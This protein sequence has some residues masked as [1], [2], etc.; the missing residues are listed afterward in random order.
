V[1]DLAT[2][3]SGVRKS[4][5]PIYKHMPPGFSYLDNAA[6]THSPQ[7][8]MQAVSGYYAQIHANPHSGSHT[9]SEQSASQYHIARETVAR[10]IHAPGPEQIIFCHS[11]TMAINMVAMSFVE[12]RI[13]AGDEILVTAMEHHANLLPWQQVAK[14]HQAILRVVPLTPSGEVDQA[15][16]HQMLSERTAFVALTHASN[17]LGTINP[18]TSMVAAAKRYGIPV[19]VDGAQAIAH[20]PVDVMACGCDFYVF[21]G[22]KV[23]GPTGIGV[24]YAAA[25]AMAQMTP[26]IYGGGMIESV[27]YTDSSWLPNQVATFEPGTPN[28]AG[29]IGLAAALDY[30]SNL[31]WEAIISHEQALLQYAL[32]TLADIPQLRVY[33]QA[34][35]RVGVLSFTLADIHAHD[36][37]S[38]LNDQQ[39]AVRGGHHC[40][41][42]LIHALGLVSVT[43]ASL[44]VYNDEQDIDALAQGLRD[45]YRVFQL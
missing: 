18:V 44:G 43:R 28:V 31:G 2:L 33:G 19:L 34:S 30:L 27:S 11:T 25:S 3:T 45:I 24:L 35:S 21:S 17:V 1:T 10:F 16:Y 42:P 8:V 40:A 39:V 12:Q 36:I 20:T 5:F 38:L 14:R 7:V 23:Y 37:T 29:A 22:H 41:M 15:A 6:T 32:D 9:L 4:D 13:K 26:S